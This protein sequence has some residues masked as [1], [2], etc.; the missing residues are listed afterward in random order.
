MRGVEQIPW[1]YDSLMWPLE[2]FGGLL[3]W[4]RAL[5]RRVRGRTLEVGCGT[6]HNLPLYDEARAEEP[7]PAVERRAAVERRGAER[8]TGAGRDPGA[9]R[10]DPVGRRVADQDLEFRL[11]AIDPGL[12]V[13]L[14]ARRRMPGVPLVV[15]GAERLPFRATTF[16]TVVSSLVFCSVNEPQQG[17]A[18]VGRVLRGDGRL[19]MMEH[20]RHKNRLLG[21][22]QDAVQPAWTWL[23][24]G[25]RPNRDTEAEVE[26]AG[27]VIEPESRRARGAMR[28]FAAFWNR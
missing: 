9:E 10:R 24:G 1:L 14:A 19:L 6:G 16:D 26:R 20:V 2:H 8:R 3:R 25:C 23:T 28:L 18:E 15:A 13:L 7:E 4:R 27:F 22:L 21:G 17:L 11:F 12:D 5:L